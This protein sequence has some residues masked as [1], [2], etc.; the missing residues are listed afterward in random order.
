MMRSS[1]THRAAH[2]GRVT[3]TPNEFSNRSESW[4]TR[5]PKLR[6]VPNIIGPLF[7][8]YPSFLDD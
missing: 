5:I 4:V 6:S 8:R 3:V 7:V 2:R 1:A